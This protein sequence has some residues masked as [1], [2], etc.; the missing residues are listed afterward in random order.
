MQ[1]Y[2]IILFIPGILR[3]VILSHLSNTSNSS[4]EYLKK[5]KIILIATA[6]ITIPPVVL[7]SLFSGYLVDIYGESYLGIEQL[8]TIVL[9]TAVISSLSNVYNQVYLSLSK[10]WYMFLA[11]AFRDLGILISVFFILR[12]YN[13]SGAMVVSLISLFFYIIYFLTLAINFHFSK[14]MEIKNI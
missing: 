9:I 6:T 11:R 2:V 4:I 5:L 12:N 14:K 3:N 8:I 13:Y 7:I 1:W 10:N